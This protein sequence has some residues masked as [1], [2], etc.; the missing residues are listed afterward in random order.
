MARQEQPETRC[1]RLLAKF[2]L[3]NIRL[4]FGR[5]GFWA[6]NSLEIR[7]ER[8]VALTF[9]FARGGPWYFKSVKWVEGGIAKFIFA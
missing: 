2:L 1:L 6:R 4:V 8:P 7:Y 3:F 5:E 9:A